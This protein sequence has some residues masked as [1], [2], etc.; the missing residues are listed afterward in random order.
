[1]SKL[2]LS[3]C[4]WLLLYSMRLSV[5]RSLSTETALALLLSVGCVPLSMPSPSLKPAA[6]AM[7]LLPPPAAAAMGAWLWR[8]PLFA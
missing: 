2:L 6:A 8:P 7:L 3:T 5:P 1:M 4:P